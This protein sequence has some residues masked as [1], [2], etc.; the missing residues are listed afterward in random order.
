[1]PK[2]Q[3]FLTQNL[4][5]IID[6]V[7]FYRVDKLRAIIE[8]Y[9]IRIEMLPP[10]LPNLNPIEELFSNIKKALKKNQMQFI[11]NPLKSFQ[12]YLKYYVNLYSNNTVRARKHFK[13]SSY[14]EVNVEVE[15]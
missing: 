14:Q 8:Q 1:M 10:Y 11:D 13:N 4:V 9:G 7:S 5:I 12:N 6:N 2:C 15:D 3:S